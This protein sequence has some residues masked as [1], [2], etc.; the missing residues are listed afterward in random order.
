MRESYVIYVI[1]TAIDIAQ[2]PT[3]IFS[4]IS[5][6]FKLKIIIARTRIENKIRNYASSELRNPKLIIAR[7]VIF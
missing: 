6:S 2:V 4:T 7:C 3:H 5:W 1:G